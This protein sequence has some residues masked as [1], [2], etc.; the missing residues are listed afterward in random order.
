MLEMM[1]TKKDDLKWWS[2]QEGKDIEITAHLLIASL[3]LDKPLESLLPVVRWLLQQR[4]AD[5]GFDSPQDTN[6]ALEALFAFVRKYPP[7]QSNRN[8]SILLKPLDGKG[9]LLEQQNSSLT[10]E[11]YSSLQYFQVQNYCD[12]VNPLK[13]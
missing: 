4:D 11:N 5:G 7:I 1:A 12:V 6:V 9:K 8:T 2:L 13:E 3:Q 10:L